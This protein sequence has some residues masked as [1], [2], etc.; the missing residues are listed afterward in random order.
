[1]IKAEKRGFTL[2]ELLV[3]IAII[4]IL[5]GLILPVLARA[6]ESA[7]RIS[8]ASNLNQIGKACFMYAD[9]PSN[10]T[11]PKVTAIDS[12]STATQNITSLGL[13]YPGYVADFHVFS[14]PS[15][16]TANLL[17]SQLKYATNG[18]PY[19]NMTLTWS[20]YQ[21]DSRHGNAEPMCGL[22]GDKIITPPLSNNHG[23][24]AGGNLLSGGGDVQ[25]II[26]SS[27]NVGLSSTGTAMVDVLSVDD[28]INIGYGYDTYLQ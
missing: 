25:F 2:I 26:L 21:Y 1:M 24:Q 9:V 5:A 22:A 14:C 11:F 18:T 4:A 15:S 16:P 17:Q 28:S 20:G 13:L 12:T 19:S 27:R 7:R 6:R 3:V 23:N 8:C 10:G